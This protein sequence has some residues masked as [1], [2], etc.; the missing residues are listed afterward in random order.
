MSYDEGDQM[1][2]YQKKYGLLIGIAILIYVGLKYLLPLVVPFIFSYFLAKALKPMLNWI[3]KKTHISKKITAPF[4]VLIIVGVIILIIAY[5]VMIFIKQVCELV[6]NL[7]TYEGLLWN[8]I[9]SICKE[10]D[11]IFGLSQGE[12]FEFVKESTT[13]MITQ[14]QESVMPYVT[15]QAVGLFSYVVQI[16][17]SCFIWILATL[18]LLMDKEGYGNTFK[19][20]IAYREI[21]PILRRLKNTG[22]AYLK[23]QG[24]IIAIIAI[25]STIGFYLVGSE[26][27]VVFGICIAI[28]DAFPIVGSGIILVPWSI[29]EIFRGNMYEAAVLITLYLICMLI[30]EGLEPKLFGDGIGIKPLYVLIA[31][32]IG[33]RLFGIG[34]IFLGPVAMVLIKAVWETKITC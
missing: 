4:F 33:V 27:A 23:A 32:F 26:F 20:T 17:T 10:C 22:F 29:V 19:R 34:G 3:E 16:G 5:I 2:D 7:P 12:S 31:V 25:V 6:S 30:R 14:M 15:K 21:R 24:I 13:T 11:K 1:K 8:N 28:F 9:C 18:I